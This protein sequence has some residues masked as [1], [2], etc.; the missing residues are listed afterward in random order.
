[1]PDNSLLYALIVKETLQKDM[2]ML[3]LHH[4]TLER[5]G[6]PKEAE[7]AMVEYVISLASFLRAEDRIAE[8]LHTL[9][10]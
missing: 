9:R 3:L 2:Q 1:M 6:L 5:A 7:E 4:D 8:T 10:N